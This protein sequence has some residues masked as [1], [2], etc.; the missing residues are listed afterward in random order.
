MTRWFESIQF[1]LFCPHSF[2]GNTLCCWFIWICWRLWY[3]IYG[4]FQMSYIFSFIECDVLIGVIWHKN[5]H[6]CFSFNI[7]YAI[8]N[9]VGIFSLCWIL[10]ADE[11]CCMS[12]DCMT[13][14]L[15]WNNAIVS[16]WY[17]EGWLDNPN[18]C[19]LFTVSGVGEKSAILLYVTVPFLFPGIL[20]G[21]FF[22]HINSKQ[23]FHVW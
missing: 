3:F 13:F 2:C 11:V 8:Y 16:G 21:N 15:D 23:Y 4:W 6:G 18:S 10:I 14:N 19:L 20:Q 17:C 12:F 1:D 9:D 7:V 5:I 22:L